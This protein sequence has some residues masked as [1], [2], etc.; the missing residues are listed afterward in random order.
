MKECELR[1]LN[2]FLNMMTKAYRKRT[3]NWVVV[4][5]IFLIG[6]STSGSTS[7]INKCKELG[8]DPYGYT[9]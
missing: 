5:D 8:I 1:I 6:T 7:C 2:N 3:I 9:I 4:R